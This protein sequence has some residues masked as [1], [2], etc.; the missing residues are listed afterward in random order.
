MTTEEINP[1]S[2]GLLFIR[3][4]KTKF[5]IVGASVT[6]QNNKF[7]V[8]SLCLVF[9]FVPLGTSPQQ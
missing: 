8:K 3:T 6:P 5:A 2:G 1:E 4:I 9:Q 7:C